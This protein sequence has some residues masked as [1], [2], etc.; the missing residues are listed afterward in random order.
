MTD[1]RLS[2]VVLS[3]NTREILRACLVA[4]QRDGYPAPR[5]V[6]VVDNASHDGSADMVAA[7]FTWVRLVRNAT[8]LLFAEGNNQGARLASGEYLC[9][10]N[11]DI[12]VRPG[13][14]LALE[15]FLASHPDYGAVVPKLLNP[16]GSV[17]R[18]CAR[19]PGLLD[20]LFQSTFLGRFPP[21]TWVKLY[22]NMVDFD[23]QR[24]RDVEQPPAACFMMRRQE[25]L[26]VG[27]FDPVLGLFFNDVDLC[28][29]L[30]RAG[31]RIRYLAEAEALHRRGSSTRASGL[32]GDLHWYRNRTAYY[33]KHYGPLAARW[34]RAVGRMWSFEYRLRIR[35][36]PRDA[37][38]RR[39]ALDELREFM[40][41]CE[42]P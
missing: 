8:N 10:M 13:A 5:E 41:Q 1:P 21:G 14:L 22:R 31:R 3:W 2:V 40:R 27:G 6:V 26:A 32:T 9:L 28:R 29:R 33:R 34:V 19:F 30:W 38:A 42:S 23:H 7:E 11:S 25:Y 20:P 12:E 37:Q 24:S 35:F 18:A 39:V 36:G 17:Q 16:D 4:L 15:E